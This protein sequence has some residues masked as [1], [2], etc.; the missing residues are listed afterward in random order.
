M[1]TCSTSALLDC[2]HRWEPPL[3]EE[4]PENDDEMAMRFAEHI[5]HRIQ[6]DKAGLHG[7]AFDDEV[8]R[9]PFEAVQ[10]VRG[11]PAARPPPQQ[12]HLPPHTALTT[13]H[14]PHALHIPTDSLSTRH[15]LHSPPTTHR[16]HHPPRQIHFPPA[17]TFTALT[18]HPPP[19]ALCTTHPDRFTFRPP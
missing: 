9:E 10:H 14:P 2:Q 8:H 18:H 12:I 3:D 16:M 1:S 13:H 11:C 7:Y 6:F 5:M 17:M 4:H 15:D 19:T